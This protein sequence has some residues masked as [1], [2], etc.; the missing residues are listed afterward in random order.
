MA[1]V[2]AAA[3]RLVDL[4][5]GGGLPGLVVAVRCPWLHVTLVERR[6]RRADLLLRAVRSLA[7]TARVTVVADD[8]Q[9]VAT[10][11]PHSFDVVTARS[12]AAPPL[13]A[14][15]AGELL[16]AGGVLV[17]SEPPTD[18]AERW[19]NDVLAAAGLADQG[20]EQ[21]IRRFLKV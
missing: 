5:S 12:F 6:T 2:P 11:T 1:A 14:R 7:L 3:R 18:V 19:P 21:G 8:V 4:G 15:W 13:T 16:V 9:V 20:R 17:V 10:A